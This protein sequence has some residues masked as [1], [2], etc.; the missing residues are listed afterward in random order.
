ME[1]VKLS[2]SEIQGRIHYIPH[3]AVVCTDK[4]ATKVRVVYDASARGKNGTSL[5]NCLHKGLKFDQNIINILIRF[6]VHRVA[7]SAEIEKAFLMVEIDEEDRNVLRFLWVDNINSSTPKIVSFR[8]T[9]VVFGVTASPFLL[10]ATI[11]H[12]LNKYKESDPVFVEKFSRSM[13]V[14]D[15][16]SGA[17]NPEDPYKLYE[18]SR[19][20][21]M[22]R[23][24]KLRKFTRNSS[25]L[26]S[27]IRF[28]EINEITPTTTCLDTIPDDGSYV[29]SMFENE[30]SDSNQEQRILGVL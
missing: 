13:Y 28:E 4:S 14:D 10:N 16:I 5:N 1:P 30:R 27:R 12:H 29:K 24:F 17:E 11:S 15:V 19:S 18:K 6:R 20:R 21:L 25:E 8:F 9:R 7:F 26:T 23:G 22:Q 3:H 2:E